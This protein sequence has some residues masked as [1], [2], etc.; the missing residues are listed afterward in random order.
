[1]YIKNLKTI[2]IK[3]RFFSNKLI[4]N[5][6]KKKGVRFVFESSVKHEDG[7]LNQPAAI[8]YSEEKHPISNSNYM[9]VVFKKDKLYLVNGQSAVDGQFIV[10]EYRGEF[11]NSV[12]CHDYLCFDGEG[13]DGGREYTRIIGNPKLLKAEIINGEVYVSND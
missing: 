11:F 4:E 3:P 6:E 10:M 1:M 5:I 12:F 8:F 7:W 9:G 2:K 13:I